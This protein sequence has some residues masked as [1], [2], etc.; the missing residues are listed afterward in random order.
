MKH[1]HCEWCDN[2]F[3]TSISYQ[4]YC[5]SDCRDLATKEKISQRYELVRR[6]RMHSKPR[7]CKT[8]KAKLSAYNDDKLCQ[9]CLIDPSDV[10]KTLKE[11]KGIADGKKDFS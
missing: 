9:A 6:K 3:E 4:I 8:C 7:Y 1:K 10:L 2:Q 5:S 11:I